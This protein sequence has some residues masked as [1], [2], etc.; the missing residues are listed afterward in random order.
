MPTQDVQRALQSAL[1]LAHRKRILYR[2]Y[3]EIIF[4]FYCSIVILSLFYFYIYHNWTFFKTY[5]ERRDEQSYRQSHLYRER[6]EPIKERQ[7]FEQRTS[8]PICCCDRHCHRGHNALQQCV[9][10]VHV[11]RVQEGKSFVSHQKDTRSRQSFYSTLL[12]SQ[13][14]SYVHYISF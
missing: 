3:I 6:L 11:Q 13:K 9:C 4:L 10:T 14:Y 5:S 12:T 8:L 2:T 7:K 1:T